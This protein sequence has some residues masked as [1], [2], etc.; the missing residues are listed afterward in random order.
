MHIAS[1]FCI[2]GVPATRRNFSIACAV[3]PLGQPNPVRNRRKGA[4]VRRNRYVV[5]NLK[6]FRTLPAGV[7]APP[8]LTDHRRG[9]AGRMA[10]WGEGTGG[11]GS[12]AVVDELPPEVR[13]GRRAARVFGWE[14][15]DSQLLAA[16][17]TS[18]GSVIELDT[19]RATPGCGV[20]RLSQALSAVESC[21]HVQ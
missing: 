6:P 2:G 14:V 3:V 13:A 17:A 11:T 5:T 12:A 20:C 19:G 8:S 15:F 4:A 9:R 10:A 7:R 16:I 18:R 1:V 21:A